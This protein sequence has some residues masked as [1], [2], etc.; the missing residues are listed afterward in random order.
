MRT[1]G[2]C[3]G[4]AVAVA[5]LMASGC[6][7]LAQQAERIRIESTTRGKP[8]VVTAEMLL[9]EKRDGRIPAMIIMHGS[10]GVRAK[11]EVAYAREFNA[12]GVAAIIIDSFS[13]R[14]I[15]T[16]VRDQSQLS[17]FDMVQDAA[18]TLQVIARHPAIDPARIGMIGFSK[19]GTVVIKS[20]LRQYTLAGNDA[21][22]ALLIAMYPW[23]GDMPFDFHAANG[24]PL[25]MLL[26]A[27]DRYAGVDSCREFARKFAAQG[28]N[29]TLKVYPDAQHDWDYPGSTHWIDAAGENSSRCIYDEISSGTWVERGSRIKVVENGNPTGNSKKASASCMTHGVSGGYNAEA[30]AQSM[31]DIRGFVR[32]YRSPSAGN[33]QRQQ[34]RVR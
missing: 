21:G 34:A 23:C 5:A 12:M 32:A 16:T 19:G 11:R 1:G 13:P 6:A 28:G 25:H 8:A 26:G 18:H 9:P 30:R 29:L 3:I 2:L 33:A 22:F 10:G 4:A 14:G 24:A 27:L 31:Q 17:S 15:R 20:A 7:T